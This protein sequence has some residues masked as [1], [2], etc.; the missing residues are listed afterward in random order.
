MIIEYAHLYVNDLL[1][2]TVNTVALKKSVEIAANVA[3]PGDQ[4]WVL[5]DDKALTLTPEQK[6][7]ATEYASRLFE[8]F[9]LGAHQIYFEKTFAAEAEVMISAL[10]QENLSTE[11]FKKQAK[12]VIFF[13]Q[14]GIKVP[15]KTVREDAVEYSCPLLASLW[16][17]FKESKCD[18]TLTIL[19]S[20]YQEVEHNVAKLLSAANYPARQNAEYIWF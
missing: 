4:L 1:A 10:P 2:G 17:K 9:G 11:T 14:D 5:L 6:Q 12:S 8:A 3:N 7:D 20:K 19:E 18:Q 15:L 13:N 16:R